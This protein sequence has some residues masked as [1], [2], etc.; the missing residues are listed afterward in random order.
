MVVSIDPKKVR[1]LCVAIILWAPLAIVIF[2]L[3]L[4]LHH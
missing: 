1:Q 2:R 4:D 3:F